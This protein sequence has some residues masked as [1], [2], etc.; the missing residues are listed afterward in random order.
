MSL[1]FYSVLLR[2]GS[3]TS[4]LFQWNDVSIKTT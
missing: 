2:N 3:L 1:I 4:A